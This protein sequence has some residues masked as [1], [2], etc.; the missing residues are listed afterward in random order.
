MDHVDCL[1]QI[2]MS[3]NP[4]HPLMLSLDRK[5]IVISNY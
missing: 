3:S 1:K 5:K 4:K 2:D